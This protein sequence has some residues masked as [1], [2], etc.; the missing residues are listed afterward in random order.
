MTRDQTKGQ[1][2]RTSSLLAFAAA[3]VLVASTSFAA[4]RDLHAYWDGR[5]ASCHGHAAQFAHKF[6]RVESGRLIGTHHK[7]ERVEAFLAHHD[8]T[9]DLHTPVIAMLK[10]QVQFPRVFAA[11][12]AGCHGTAAD[13][14]RASLRLEKDVRIGKRSGQPVIGDLENEGGVN[15]SRAPAVVESLRRRVTA[16]RPAS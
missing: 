13:F 1:S 12:C 7:E 15:A 2:S 11:K 4:D 6:L 5:C 8:L 9:T 16:V 14:A 10:A 3:A